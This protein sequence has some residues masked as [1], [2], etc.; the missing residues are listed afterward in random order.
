MRRQKNAQMEL[1]II[2][3]LALALVVIGGFFIYETIIT[4]SPSG[5]IIECKWD[6]SNAKWSPCVK[7]LSY[8]NI[9]KCV[10]ITKE[11]LESIPKPPD[12]TTCN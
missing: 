12:I 9:S 8:R 7:D 11:C 3:G 10:P 5:N 6:C 1:A 4:K 2:K